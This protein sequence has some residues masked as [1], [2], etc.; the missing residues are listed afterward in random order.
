MHRQLSVFVFASVASVILTGSISAQELRSSRNSSLLSLCRPK[1]GQQAVK[2]GLP[3][4]LRQI[5]KL[6]RDALR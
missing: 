4:D 3:A 1:E 6:N 5:D 2:G